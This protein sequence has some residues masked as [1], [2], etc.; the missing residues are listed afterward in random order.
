MIAMTMLPDMVVCVV[1][2]GS[3]WKLWRWGLRVESAVMCLWW[4][5]RV[6]CFSFSCVELE[7]LKL[8]GEVWQ[9]PSSSSSSSIEVGVDE[10]ECD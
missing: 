4:F 2:C 5:M 1:W 3:G 10:M 9:R 6:L 8:L 7:S